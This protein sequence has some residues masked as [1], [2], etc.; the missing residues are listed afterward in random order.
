MSKA[1]LSLY[2]LQKIS[3]KSEPKS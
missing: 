1:H 2:T 3:G